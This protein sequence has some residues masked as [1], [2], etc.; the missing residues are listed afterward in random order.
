[1]TA[2]SADPHSPV[3][4]LD[5]RAL[6]EELYQLLRSMDRSQ[7][8][9]AAPRELAARLH[10]LR[11]ELQ[12]L[13]ERAREEAASAELSAL[14]AR[15][16]A[17]ADT[18]AVPLPDLNLPAQQARQSWAELRARL[19]PAYEELAGALHALD[20][21]VP[22]VRPHNLARSAT[23]MASG[24]SSILV[25]ASGYAE[26]AV[27]GLILFQWSLDLGR[28]VSPGL[29]TFMNTH[30]RPI[31]HP[32]EMHRIT[33]SSWYS[34]GLGLAMLISGGV[35]P[36][37]FL[38]AAILGFSDPAAGIIGR[39]FGKH[40]IV[41]GRSVEGSAAF[42]AA[43]LLVGVPTLLLFGQAAS[44]SVALTLGLAAVIPAALV[45]LFVRRLD[46]NLTIPVAAAAGARL[47]ELY[48]LA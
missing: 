39:R 21:S 19:V 16:V 36:A 17:L 2:L 10:Q 31:A 28:W 22:S 24:L 30:F 15:L 42:V 8:G 26:F 23:H 13:V 11:A 44:L 5:S 4:A 47:A 45:E 29:R 32:H 40:R 20:L 48:L 9:R 46:D 34:L 6:A 1:M 33:S 7:W 38:A 3:L 27:V 14:R 12:A 35:G 37:A 43:G 18:A 25:C 41:N